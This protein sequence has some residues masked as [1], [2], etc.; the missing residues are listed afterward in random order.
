MLASSSKWE[1]TEM[2]VTARNI[3]PDIGND[4]SRMKMN[5]D[6]AVES[7]ND[8]NE[9][10]LN[11]TNTDQLQISS[12]LRRGFSSLTL[13]IERYSKADLGISAGRIGSKRVGDLREWQ[14]SLRANRARTLQMEWLEQ[15][16][17]TV[18]LVVSA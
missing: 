14:V 4:D 2:A 3:L 8:D 13:N 12:K 17:S 18:K 16:Q 6:S 15:S 9:K 7:A 1:H 10:I 11:I 5:G